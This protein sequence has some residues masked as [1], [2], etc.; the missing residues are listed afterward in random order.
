MCSKG[1]EEIFPDLNE[2]PHLPLLPPPPYLFYLVAASVVVCVESE[3]AGGG[4]GGGGLLWR[5]VTVRILVE[6]SS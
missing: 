1:R 2:V 3:A 6:K 4:G 5:E